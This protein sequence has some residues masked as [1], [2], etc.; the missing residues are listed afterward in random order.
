MWKKKKKF[1]LRVNVVCTKGQWEAFFKKLYEG[2]SRWSYIDT[3]DL[4]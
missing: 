4:K 3:M 1:Y 2:D